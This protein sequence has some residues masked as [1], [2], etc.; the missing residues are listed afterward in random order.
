VGILAARRV[1]V[2]LD[3]GA[4]EAETARVLAVAG[5]QAVASDVPD[6]LPAGL[7]RLFLPNERA[8]VSPDPDLPR[9]GGQ[10]ISAI[11]VMGV[12]GLDRQA[13]AAM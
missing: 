4:P 9:R 1:A 5:P 7:R 6:R 3:P 11:T 8:A 12:R 13:G 10:V 2:P